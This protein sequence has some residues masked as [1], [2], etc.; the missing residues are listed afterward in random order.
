MQGSRIKGSPFLAILGMIGIHFSKPPTRCLLVFGGMLPYSLAF[1]DH[2]G[3]ASHVLMSLRQR[4]LLD[5]LWWRVG[6]NFFGGLDSLM[7]RPFFFGGLEPTVSN[8]TVG[9]SSNPSFPPFFGVKSV[10]SPPQCPRLSLSAAAGQYYIFSMV[11][12]FGALALAA[13]MNAR[14]VSTIFLSYLRLG[15]HGGVVG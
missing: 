15:K 7:L 5:H 4:N 11:Q 1:L 6:T 14:Q 10:V 13:A 3:F 2:P 9:P 12:S 8:L